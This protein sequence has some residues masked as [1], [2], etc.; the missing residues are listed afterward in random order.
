MSSLIVVRISI[1]RINENNFQ[2]RIADWKNII[3]N[4]YKVFESMLKNIN[5]DLIDD[6]LDIIKKSMNDFVIR[7]QSLK[8]YYLSKEINT[9]NKE[10]NRMINDYNSFIIST[11]K[12]ITSI[13]NNNKINVDDLIMYEADPIIAPMVKDI[14]NLVI[15][16]IENEKLGNIRSEINNFVKHYL[17]DYNKKQPERENTHVIQEDV[18]KIVEEALSLIEYVKNKDIKY[19]SEDF[20]KYEQELMNE[21]DIVRIKLVVENVK[22]LFLKFKKYVKEKQEQEFYTQE[23]NNLIQEDIDEKLKG[24]IKALLDQRIIRKEDFE[25]IRRRYMLE[26]INRNNMQSYKENIIE[27]MGRSGC[28]I[29]TEDQHGLIYF[30]TPFGDEY[31]IRMKFNDKDGSVKLQF[32]KYI[33]KEEDRLSAY[34]KQVD[35]NNAKKFCQNIDNILQYIETHYGIELNIEERMEPEERVFYIKKEQLQQANMQYGKKE[36]LRNYNKKEL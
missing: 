28:K 25:A 1:E 7:Y 3:D 34:E 33:D 18:S 32:V 31:K 6:I 22:F 4:E 30:D 15:K 9:F 14:K 20:A 36:K 23:L 26:D 2:R 5:T 12:F 16:K 27:A 8:N 29:L 24:D 21:K 19:Y 35:L 13:S 17:K 11:K 10:F